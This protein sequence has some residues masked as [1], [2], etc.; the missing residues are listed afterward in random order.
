MVQRKQIPPKRP[1]GEK[2]C[3]INP[4]RSFG[5]DPFQ[6]M[7]QSQHKGNGGQKKKTGENSA[8]LRIEREVPD[9]KK[10]NSACGKEN[11]MRIAFCFVA[12]DPDEPADQ[13]GQKAQDREVVCERSE[14]TDGLL[15]HRFQ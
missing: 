5:P 10:S 4:P 6:E 7:A 13:A 12:R 2:D 11:E 1:G 8:R 15:K 9:Q 3:R 14:I